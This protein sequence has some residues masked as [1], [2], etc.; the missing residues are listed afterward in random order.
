MVKK[1]L[2]DTNAVIELL[3]GSTDSK[4]LENAEWIG[5]SIITALEFLSFPKLTI[6]DKKLFNKFSERIEV[7]DLTIL[8][9]THLN[10][11]I[12]LRKKYKLKL[13]D[14]II[15]ATSISC[16]SYLITN[17]KHFSRIKELKI[18]TL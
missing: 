6:H 3:Q 10:L 5:I 14:A 4:L 15:A 9:K 1:Y 11:C 8:N 16:K 7:I 17:D 18:K 2:L 13:P 12:N